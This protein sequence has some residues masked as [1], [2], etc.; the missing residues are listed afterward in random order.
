MSRLVVFFLFSTLALGVL[1]LRNYSDQ[2][3]IS[4]S[5]DMEKFEKDQSEKEM[6]IYKLTH[7]VEEE[8][9]VVEDK[10]KE[11]MVV[12]E[13]DSEKRG[14]ELY[15][16]K[17][18]AI[19]HGKHGMGKKSQNAP[20]ISGQYDWYNFKQLSAMKKGERVNAVMNPYLK[21]LNDEDFK[22]ISAFLAKYSW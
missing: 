21:S 4:A 17:N 2:S 7:P 3:I 5:F 9:K 13:T 15:K 11:P 10:P 8:K 19:C 22:D 14:A 20:R 1:T 16:K 12:L 18:C 6:L